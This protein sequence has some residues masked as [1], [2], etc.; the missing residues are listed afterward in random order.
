MTTEERGPS[1]FNG[2]LI[3]I[4]GQFEITQVGHE[5]TEATDK[6]GSVVNSVLQPAQTHECKQQCT[7]T[8]LHW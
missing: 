6:L 8:L 5:H 2:T 7:Y 4:C 3:P 1:T